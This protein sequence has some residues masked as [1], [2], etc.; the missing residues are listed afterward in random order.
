MIKART[1]VFESRSK[2][3]DEE[4]IQAFIAT[5]SWSYGYESTR[6]TLSTEISP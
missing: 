4:Y 2:A 6:H 3:G 1:S 5:Q